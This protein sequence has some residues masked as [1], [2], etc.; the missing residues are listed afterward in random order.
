MAS[1]ARR[2]N[3]QFAE[4][5]PGAFARILGKH[6]VDEI[7]SVLMELPAQLQ[8]SIAARLPARKIQV[9]TDTAQ[10][11]VVRWM[12]DGRF[13]DAV[14]LL[15]RVGREKRLS[16]VQGVGNE[17]R[18]RRLLRSQQYPA[19]SVGTLVQDFS[20]QITADA[21]AKDVAAELRE[22][23]DSDPGALVVTDGSGGYVGMLDSWRL[24]ANAQ[25]DGSVR[26]YLDSI[27]GVHPEMPISAVAARPEWNTSNWL[28]VVDQA[29]RVLGA[30]SRQRVLAAAAS[31]K[32]VR[33]RD[34]LFDLL[35]ELVHVAGAV[36]ER[37]L[38]T[39]GSRR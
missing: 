1:D 11:D 34:I 6:D 15:S 39:P 24:L 2:L 13:E 9:L 37:V 8:A 26:N 23:G 29:Q 18:K 33:S 30:V 20:V 7:R 12:T 16:L 3:A 27:P 25:P 36:T 19:H 17:K 4:K 31:T 14:A 22:M 35:D 38:R 32:Q 5:S 28:P 21:R 10:A